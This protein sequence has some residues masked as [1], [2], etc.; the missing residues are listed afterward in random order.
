M[1]VH[2]SSLWLWTKLKQF[3]AKITLHWYEV[4][5]KGHSPVRSVTKRS[6]PMVDARLLAMLEAKGVPLHEIS[7]EVLGLS[8]R[9][10]SRLSAVGIR[11]MQQLSNCSQSDLFSVPRFGVST[12]GRI[13]A[14]LNSYLRAILNGSVPCKYL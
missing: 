13:K 14:K 7:V 5:P 1:A 2:Q 6:T 12:V 8:G 9:Q 11:N 3:K 10:S 4:L